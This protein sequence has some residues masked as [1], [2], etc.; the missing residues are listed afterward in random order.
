MICKSY[1]FIAIVLFVMN[2]YV[3]SGVITSEANHNFYVT[4]TP[5]LIARYK[6]I[7]AE[8]Y[9]IYIKGMVIGV[10]I[11]VFA[12]IL[13]KENKALNLTC[14]VC[15][16]AAVTFVVNCFYYLV[17]PKSDYMVPHLTTKKQKEA[18]VKCYRSYQISYITGLFLGGATAVFFAGGIC[19]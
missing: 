14:K 19:L 1:C 4:L 7:I 9:A 13:L 10:I 17:H 3:S 8:R 15:L 6:K 11:G 2:I 16:V 12:A 5:Q 18:W